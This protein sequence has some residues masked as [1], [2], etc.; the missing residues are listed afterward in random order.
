MPK[1]ATQVRSPRRFVAWLV[2]GIGACIGGLAVVWFATR[3]EELATLR[4]H[5]GPVRSVVIDP[6]Q[7]LIVTAGDDGRIRLWTL[8]GNR[9]AGIFAAH[10]PKVTAIC[11]AGGRGDIA[12]VGPDKKLIRWSL[13][14]GK[15][16][17]SLD[18]PAA[19]ECVAASA[20]GRYIAVG[21]N[22]DTIRLFG[23]SESTPRVLK[24]HTKHVQ[25]VTFTP[26]GSRLL[27]A[28]TDG[29]IRFWDA[30]T[31]QPKERI[32]IGHHV[33]H[34]LTISP[35][36]SRLVAA[37]T[38]AGLRQ[39]GLPSREELPGFGTDAGMA[40]CVAISP[41]GTRL[42]TGHEDGQ[43]K[44]WEADSRRLVHSYRGHGG[45]L[46]ALAFDPE[47]NTILSAAGDGLIKRWR[48]AAR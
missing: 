40:W 45:V 3:G 47:G 44:L 24:G 29:T 34:G 19:P 13:P 17:N 32:D 42:A 28:S 22:D 36:G 39:W 25:C 12:S 26:D 1:T 48:V 23:S 37:V 27:S 5:K 10:E 33:V 6:D 8:D 4:G 16:I 43:V 9:S 7:R 11:R 41:D 38:G 31:G 20:D 14:D 18:L 35:D 46:L 30:A 15:A 21:G 2:F